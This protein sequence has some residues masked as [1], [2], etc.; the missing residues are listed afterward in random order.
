MTKPL[1]SLLH[2]TQDIANAI[3]NSSRLSTGKGEESGWVSKNQE[4]PTADWN[5]RRVISFFFSS[6]LYFRLKRRRK[7]NK[8]AKLVCHCEACR[9]EHCG[10]D[11]TF[12][13]ANS[14]PSWREAVG[15]RSSGLFLS[16]ITKKK[17]QGKILLA[18]QILEQRQAKKSS[19]IT[20]NGMELEWWHL[21]WHFSWWRREKNI[22]NGKRKENN[23]KEM[24]DAM[25]F[26]LATVS[27]VE[28][29]FFSS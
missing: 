4:N 18:S 29:V 10:R 20:E 14:S 28:K 21:Q 16:E 5:C 2:L 9:G 25:R 22:F 13:S 7:K 11:R 17:T 8:R 27:E 1:T 3:S 15:M 12:L 23:V 24:V 6:F 26:K 19:K